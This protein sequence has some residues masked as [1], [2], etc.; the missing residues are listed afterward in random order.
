MLKQAIAIVDIDNVLG[1]SAI[2]FLEEINS[3]VGSSFGF[4]DLMEYNM[5]KLPHVGITSELVFSIITSEVVLAKIS[6]LDF[7]QEA[8]H[9]LHALKF[10]IVLVTARLESDRNVTE[11]WLE[12][13][14]LYYDELIMGQ[15]KDVV[16]RDL[17]SMHTAELVVVFEDHADN[18]LCLA[19]EG[20]LVF[21]FDK[22]WNR[23][24]PTSAHIHRV[25]GW[26]HVLMLLRIHNIR[27]PSDFG[28]LF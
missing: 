19:K 4:H 20:A 5:E 14:N 22:P 17:V 1:D 6:L 13:Y 21:L 15:Q 7:S 18:A 8:L 2:T 27:V 16:M 11:E 3:I 25:K 26:K 28:W 10:H 23:N 9:S 24:V 12:R